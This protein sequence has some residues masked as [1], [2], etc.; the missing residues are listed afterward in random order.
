MTGHPPKGT[1][2]IG[3]PN[4]VA[5][6]G[7]W[8]CRLGHGTTHRC[9]GLSATA[10]AYMKPIIKPGIRNSTGTGI[11]TTTGINTRTGTGARTHEPT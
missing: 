10:H 3:A 2:P 8:T 1:T 6:W 4:T 5:L 7:P 11:C 9:T